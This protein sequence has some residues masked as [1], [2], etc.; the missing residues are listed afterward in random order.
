MIHIVLKLNSSTYVIKN[1][2]LSFIGEA[3]FLLFFIAT[4]LYIFPPIFIILIFSI[5]LTLKLR[6]LI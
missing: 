5:L 6:Y 1:F 4:Y 2:E 3:L